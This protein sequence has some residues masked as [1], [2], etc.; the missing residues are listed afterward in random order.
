MEPELEPP[1]YA[2]QEQPVL[3]PAPLA[4]YAPVPGVYQFPQPEFM[5]EV[6]VDQP[7]PLPS[8]GS[9][10]NLRKPRT[11]S[12]QRYQSER[13]ERVR[14]KDQCRVILGLFETHEDGL[15]RA[16]QPDY[17]LRERLCQIY[18]A[19]S[20]ELTDLR[21]QDIRTEAAAGSSFLHLISTD[22]V[23]YGAGFGGGVL[24]LPG[25]VVDGRKRR[26][27]GESLWVA[28]ERES[29]KNQAES[30]FGCRL[31]RRKQPAGVGFSGQLGYN[32]APNMKCDASKVIVRPLL[33]FKG[34]PPLI[35]RMRS[36]INSAKEKFALS[37]EILDT[38][39]LPLLKKTP[40]ELKSLLEG[41]NKKGPTFR[42]SLQLYNNA[43]AFTSVGANVD[44]GINNGGGPYVYRVFGEVYHQI[45][46]LS[47][48]SFEKAI[49]SQIYMYDNHPQLEERL[50]FPNGDNRLDVE[51]TESLSAMMNR[52]NALFVV[53]AWTC[54]EH[55]RLG[56]VLKNQSILRSNLYNNIVDSVN[57]GD[58]DAT[59]VGKRIVLPSSFTC[60]PCYMQ[61][62]YQDCMAICRRFGSPDLFIIFTCNPQWP[63]IKDFCDKI[64]HCTPAE[65]PDILARVFKI[66]LDLLLEDLTKKHVLGKVIGVAYTIEF[67]KR[68]LPHAHII[69]WLEES[70]KCHSTDEIVHLIFAEIPDQETDPIG[71]ETI[72]KIYD[73][74]F[75]VPYNRGLTV[76]YQAHINIEWY[77]QGRL[78][79]YMFKYVTKGPDRATIAIGKCKDV[80]SA[81]DK[82]NI[83]SNE[84]DDYIACRYL[85]SA[86]ACWRI[87]KFPIH[88]RKPVVTK[89]LFHLE[90]EQQVCFKDDESLPSVIDRIN[91]E[92]TM[93][94][95]WL[96]INIIDPIARGLTF[97]EFPEKF[98]WDNTNKVWKRR[99]NNI[100]MVGH[101]IYM[102]PTAGERFY[103]RM[104][105]NIVRGATSYKDIRTVNNV[106]CNTYKKAC[107]HHGLLECDD[108]WHNAIT[109]ASVHQIGAQL[110]ELF[111][112][113]LLFCD[114]SDVRALWEKYWK[115][116][117]ND[118]E[119][120][121]RKNYPRHNFVISDEQ[122]ECLTLFDIEL[123][124]RKRGKS[125]ADFPTL[126]KLDKDLQQQ[127]M[128]TI[129]YEECMYD[130]HVLAVEGNKCLTMLNERQRDVFQIV[131][132]NV[133]DKRGGLYFVYGYGGTGKTFLWKTIIDNLRSE[134]K[135]ILAVASSGI[136]SLLIQG[137]RTAHSR[138]KI[139][140]DI[141]E[142]STY[143][144]K[145]KSFL[146]EL[147]VQSDLIIWDEA[148]M[149]HKHVFES[150]HRSFRD[151]MRHK[152]VSNLD[153]PF[154]GKTVLLGGDFRQILPVLPKKGREDIVMASV[155]RSYLWNHCKVFT[156]DEN[157]RIESGVPPVTISGQKI[158]YADWVIGVGDGQVPAVASVEG[159]EPTWV[160]ISPELSIDP[161]NNGKQV[162]IDTIYAQLCNQNDS[163][164]YRDSAIL[165]PLNEDVYLINKEVLKRFTGQQIFLLSKF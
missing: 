100:Y 164:Y 94:V 78:I 39:R 98:L 48:T 67:Q 121:Q 65:R 35:K 2:P 52:E 6:V 73:S 36:I 30:C 114:I 14:W 146:A 34:L 137:G 38:V 9:R 26:K 95:Q 143:D 82:C 155:N 120:K 110:R 11:V 45:G 149:N 165:T 150:I 115:T 17:I 158:S 159:N 128:N 104:L 125:V 153:K 112:T 46:S 57:K 134:V 96:R 116:F 92:V 90:N 101:L 122:I 105:L 147:I 54:I 51:I 1:V 55:T 141:N 160:K 69:I 20:Q 117:S 77:N 93:F 71:Y 107:F 21:Q 131:V 151:L 154:R 3:F 47:P 4:V 163:E 88:Y 86:E 119:H 8:Q 156:L 83:V 126:P 84:V 111:V 49:F 108:E 63:E 103:L 133:R 152:D 56:W 44:R 85:S 60:S 15:V 22:F 53:D 99:K 148:L 62:N 24:E 33:E 87:F 40:P 136:A 18:R 89:L 91:P 37:D 130:R 68:G 25:V 29:Q 66:K 145:Q 50:N 74:W 27:A 41:T 162:I 132:D 64:P 12:Y 32:A 81:E 61:Q 31:N 118:I 13:E 123:Q 59:T 140:I 135:I 43:F 97:V 19:G 42:K 16:L 10:T 58:T 80:D 113:L 139:P 106:I 76:K 28:R 23:E 109:D 127:S 161:G 144:I 75:V 124:L 5:D 79:K 72:S 157:M 129:L 142:N 138:F 7:L 102:H 70:D